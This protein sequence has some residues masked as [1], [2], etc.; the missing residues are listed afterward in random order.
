MPQDKWNEIRFSVPKDISGK[1][2]LHFENLN[3]N[4]LARAEIP[5]IVKQS[6]VP[7]FIKNNAE[8]CKDS[9]SD[10]EFLKGIEYMIAHDVIPISQTTQ[11]TAGK[12]IPAWVKNNACWWANDS[13]ADAEFIDAIT[14]LVKIGL[15][16]P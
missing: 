9:I 6:L 11:N 15:I 7:P 12:E 5:V 3:D 10:A 16:V 8:W 13:I 4:D 14:F 1:I 2:V